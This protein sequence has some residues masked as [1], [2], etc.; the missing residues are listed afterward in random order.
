M[1]ERD[2]FS[3][4]LKE[5]RPLSILD[6]IYPLIQGYDSVKIKADIEFGGTD[7]K[8]NLIV[9]RHIQES[10]GQSP[11]IVVTM[12]LLVG[13]DGKSKMSKSLGNYIGITEEPFQMFGKLMSI[14]DLTMWEYFRLLTDLDI[15]KIKDMHPKEAKLLLAEKIVSEYHSPLVAK[16]TKEEFERIFSRRETPRDLPTFTVSEKKVDL[17]EFLYKSKVVSSRNQ[18]R[19]LLLQKGIREKEKDAPLEDRILA[20]PPQ[21]LIL[22]VG[23]RKFLKVVYKGEDK[24]EGR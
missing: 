21:G 22:K 8:F 15:E 6:F 24:N 9:G 11:Q 23:K 1:L 16:R 12:P 14:S 3:Q 2:D 7:Q 19:R 17:V 18:A 4:R 13:V 5:N 20:I 10:M